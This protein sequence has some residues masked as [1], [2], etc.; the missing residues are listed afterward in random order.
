MKIAIH[1]PDYIP[2]LG[3]FYKMWQVEKFVYLDD[4]QFSNANWHH[5]NRIKTPQGETRLKIPVEQH[6][7][8]LINC[9][10]TKDELGWKE[11]HLKAI[12][13]NYGGTKYFNDFFK[14]FKELLLPNYKSIAELNIMIN[15]F[16]AQKFGFNIKF[17][18]SSDMNIHTYREER[19]LD[20]CN[21]LQ[22]TT[23]ISGNGARAYEEEDHFIARGVNLIYTDYQAI[24]YPQAWGEFIPNLSVIDF[25]CNCGYDWDLVLKQVLKQK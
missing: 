16:I 18:K 6:L 9:V 8:Y 3:L 19:V 14:D 12:E 21:K 5:W 10:R 24:E 25:I 23:Y 2:Y 22:A 7:G 4:C 11:K 20:I 15:T 1:Q 13:I 17:L